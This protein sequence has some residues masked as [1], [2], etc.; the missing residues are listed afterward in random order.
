MSVDLPGI[1]RAVPGNDL[2]IDRVF[3]VGV[4]I[5]GPIDIKYFSDIPSASAARAALTFIMDQNVEFQL[6][7]HHHQGDIEKMHRAAF[8]GCLAH[9]VPIPKRF[10]GYAKRLGIVFPG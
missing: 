2:M 4:P 10:A 6:R 9:S 5:E 8:R 7:R 1:S 3:N